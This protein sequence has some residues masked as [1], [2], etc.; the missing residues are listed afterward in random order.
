MLSF[1]ENYRNLSTT[2]TTYSA[3]YGG[4]NKFSRYLFDHMPFSL[5]K[6]CVNIS[7]AWVIETQKI[8]SLLNELTS[9]IEM[10]ESAE[11]I[12]KKEA[13]I[14]IWLKKLIKKYTDEW[15][16]F[17]TNLSLV[18]PTDSEIKEAMKN[19]RALAK[20]SEEDRIVAEVVLDEAERLL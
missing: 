14:R 7:S 4:S 18:N 5:G 20:N 13:E 1:L 12:N 11:N 2:I 15:T 3:T 6:R 16:L 10:N 8:D 17:N 9:L 19:T